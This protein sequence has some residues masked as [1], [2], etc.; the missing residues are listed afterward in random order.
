MRQE[1]FAN[2]AETTL[3][4]AI[5]DS[6]TSVAVNDASDFPSEGD[7]RVIIEN[8]L[9]LVTAVSGNTFTVV[10]G[11]ESTV[12]AAHAESESIF[13]I[14]TSGGLEKYI[15]EG[16]PLFGESSLPGTFN[17]KDASGVTLDASDFTWVN[18]GTATATDLDNGPILMY[19]MTAGG[20]RIL[21][22]SAPST[23]Y[24][25]T[26]AFRPHLQHLTTCSV[27][28]GFRESST[29]KLSLIAIC[30]SQEHFV[31]N[32]SDPST[33]NS[34][35]WARTTYPYNTHIHWLR[36]SDDGANIKFETS[37]TGLAWQELANPSRTSYMA[38]GPDQVVWGVNA[39]S[40]TD[41]VHAALVHWRE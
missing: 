30:K 10:R 20:N 8:E 33:F 14:I 22:R 26:A 28:L 7:F 3:S 41:H 4:S 38:G 6:T 17:L 13:H 5:D 12:A 24:T 35:V 36:I 1:R 25:I 15:Q 16:V 2:D 29:G 27:F 31:Y 32:Y 18:Q 19:D 9:M 40:T 37:M 23:P 11:Y 34:A 21:S 39:N